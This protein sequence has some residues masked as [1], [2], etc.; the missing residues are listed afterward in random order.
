MPLEAVLKT[1]RTRPSHVK[2]VLSGH[3][4]LSEIIALADVNE[5]TMVK[6]ALKAGI[7]AQRGFEEREP[8]QVMRHERVVGVMV[9]AQD[10]EA[11]RNFYADRLQQT[12]VQSA[13]AAAQA[14][15]TPEALE[16]LLADE[17]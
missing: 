10:F 9:S 16:A 17:S 12:L 1:L 15:L 7:P 4:C 14:G 13:D 6:H 11:M 8:V 3:R 5:V 2:L